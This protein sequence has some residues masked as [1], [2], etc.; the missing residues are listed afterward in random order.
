MPDFT[1]WKDNGEV[2]EPSDFEVGTSIEAPD[3]ENAAETFMTM[4]GGDEYEVELFVRHEETGKFRVVTVQNSGWSTIG[5]RDIT[6]Y[7]LLTEVGE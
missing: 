7:A 4:N 2:M 5:A 1:I 3:F 6:L